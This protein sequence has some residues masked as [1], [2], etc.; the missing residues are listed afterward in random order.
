MFESHMGQTLL[1]GVTQ[2]ILFYAVNFTQKS[3]LTNVN[4]DNNRVLAILKSRMSL[5]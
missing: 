2:K 4:W 5:D 3:R 1:T